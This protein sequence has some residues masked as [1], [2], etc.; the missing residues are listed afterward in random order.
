MIAEH[1]LEIARPPAEVYAFLVDQDNWAA[2][3]PATLGIDPRGDVHVGM[4]GTITRRVAGRRVRN[5]FV[6]TELEP[7]TRM[8]MRLTGAGY[9]LTET[10]TLEA[11]P[12]GT[13]VIRRPRWADAC[14]SRS[15][16]P[17]SVGI[18]RLVQGVWPRSWRP[19]RRGGEARSISAADR[20]RLPWSRAGWTWHG[21]M[22]V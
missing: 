15:P 8:G 18:S 4:A 19:C 10:T 3:D 9:V 6:V 16:V 14:S 12:D 1:R 5:G 2:L 17:S 13:H 21:V 22:V 7:D 20:A 11:T